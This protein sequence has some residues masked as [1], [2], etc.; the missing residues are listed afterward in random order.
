MPT[1]STRSTSTPTSGSACRRCPPAPTP[2]RTDRPHP[3][4]R[5]DPTMSHLRR[6]AVLLG[7]AAALLVGPTLP[8]GAEFA[9][10][11]A[12]TVAIGSADVTAPT[13]LSTDGTTCES[14]Q[15]EKDE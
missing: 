4:R 9:D 10:S 8:A 1:T 11:A 15:D 6:A 2:T 7:T 13:A 14:E 12:T 3:S 5:E